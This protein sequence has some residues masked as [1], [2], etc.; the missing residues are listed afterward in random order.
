MYFSSGRLRN[1]ISQIKDGAT[2]GVHMIITD[3]AQYMWFDSQQNG[4]KFAFSKT[5]PNANATKQGGLD[6]TQSYDFRCVSW[7]VD[8]S[9]FT[10]PATVT[11]TD[12]TQLQVPGM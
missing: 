2:T 7:N 10:P 1:D 6:A 5:E 3:A 8:E 12:L 11:F 9:F 4:L